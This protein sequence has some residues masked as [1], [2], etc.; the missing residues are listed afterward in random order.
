MNKELETTKKW[1]YEIIVQMKDGTEYLVWTYSKH[2]DADTKLS[3][4]GKKLFNNASEAS[5]ASHSNTAIQWVLGIKEDIKNKR[6]DRV[7]DGK[8]NP[9]C[10]Y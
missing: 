10:T 2:F 6:E 1:Q 7:K 5:G 8:F 9:K 3:R 4:K